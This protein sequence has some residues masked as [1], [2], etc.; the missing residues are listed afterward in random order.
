MSVFVHIYCSY[1]S[2]TANYTYEWQK[3]WKN[4]TQVTLHQ[5]MAKDN[6]PFHTVVFPATLIGADD[7]YTLLNVM[8]A[9]GQPN[10]V[11]SDC[12]GFIYTSCSI[13][14]VLI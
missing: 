7:N 8:S 12:F 1:L 9:T 4:P 11:D 14:F 3:W 2:I 13:R 5:F 6:V 10:G